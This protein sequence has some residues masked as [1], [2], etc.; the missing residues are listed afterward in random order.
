MALS[1]EAKAA[2]L[3]D[4]LSKRL[5]QNKEGEELQL[6]YLADLAHL[7]SDRIRAAI[8]ASVPFHAAIA[9]ATE[10]YRPHLNQNGADGAQFCVLLAKD[11]RAYLKQLCAMLFP[12]QAFIMCMD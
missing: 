5:K 10:A 1:M 7:F 3:A 4:N 6:T 8:N 12:V 9:D 2:V 11:M